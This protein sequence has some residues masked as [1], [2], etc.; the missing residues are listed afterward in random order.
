MIRYFCDA[1]GKEEKLEYIS[2]H[3]SKSEICDGDLCP[4]CRD[5]IKKLIFDIQLES[6][7]EILAQ[8][9]NANES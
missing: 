5:K 2:F 8:K 3:G 6:E 7:K 9:E 4:E 1:C